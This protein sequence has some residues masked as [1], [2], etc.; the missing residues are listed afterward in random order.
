MTAR[1][2]GADGFTLVEVV[3][4]VALLAISAT[5]F[6]RTTATGM[7]LV[8]TSKE[9]QTAVQLAGEWMEEARAVPYSGLALPEGTVFE[10]APTPD[11]GVD[12]VAQTYQV[13]GGVVEALALDATGAFEHR[14]S[15][16]LNGVP[17]EVYRYVTWV[18]DGAVAEAYKRVTVV[19][20]WDGTSRTEGLQELVQ[21]TIVSTDGIEWTSTTTTTPSGSSTT[22]TTSSST[23][24]TTID[25]AACEGDTTPPSFSAKIL[26]GVGAETGFS[27]SSTITVSLDATDPCLPMQVALANPAESYGPLEA[28]AA[29]T[30]WELAPGDGERS[31]W[32]KVTDA[33]GNAAVQSKTIVVDTSPPSTPATFTA[34][35]TP[36]KSVQLTWSESTDDQALSGYRVWAKQANRAY[37]NLPL[38]TTLVCTGATCTWTHGGLSARDVW[39]YYVEAV[40]AAGNASGRTVERTVAI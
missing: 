38:G 10:T 32:I 17:M 7:H 1:L 26:A 24:S 30:T 31:V 15:D 37:G 28:Y 14:T 36:P 21:S 33:A 39:T 22:T 20:Q 11:G 35:K 9:R 40:D 29:S 12:Q 3:V 5:A 34:V 8:G 4:A 13:P 2:R 6:L 18:P 19:V 16:V 27:N 23:T 25:P